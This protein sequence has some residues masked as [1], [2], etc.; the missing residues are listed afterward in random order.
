MDRIILRLGRLMADL[1]LN[2]VD[3]VWMTGI[4]QGTISKL[5]SGYADQIKLEHL[6]KI[7]TALE[8]DITEIIEVQWVGEEPRLPREGRYERVNR[9]AAYYKEQRKK[10][11]AEKR[12]PIP[13]ENTDVPLK[14]E[15]KLTTTDSAAAKHS[16]PART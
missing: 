7:M 4:R 10:M 1:N 6:G 15:E 3:L 8:A 13:P 11:N 5:I 9:N 14:T 12:K 16:A 2:D